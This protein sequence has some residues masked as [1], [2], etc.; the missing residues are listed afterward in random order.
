[1]QKAGFGLSKTLR[2]WTILP[3]SRST[4]TADSSLPSSG[5]VVSQI[6]LPQTTGDD[7]PL[8]W[9]AVFQRTF[10]DSDQRIG[11]A[12][13][14]CPSAVGPRKAGQLSDGTAATGAAART[15]ASRQRIGMAGPKAVG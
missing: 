10:S 13:A 6:C 9:M 2:S 8:P 5:A 12:D 3:V 11:A 4:Q 1:M 15:A 14:A 7:Q